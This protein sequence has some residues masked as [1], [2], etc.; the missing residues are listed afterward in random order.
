MKS[1]LGFVLVGVGVAGI[2]AACSVSVDTAGKGCPCPDGLLCDTSTNTCVTTLPVSTADG[3]SSG[4]PPVAA[5]NA[6]ECPC[7][8]NADCHDPKRAYCGPGGTC[9]E[10]LSTPSDTCTAGG[11]CNATNECVAGCKSDS[12]CSGK[13][14]NTTAHRCV[15]CVVDGDC[16][17]AGAN[18]KCSPSGTCAQSCAG[19]G[20]PC[21]TGGTCCGSF[22]L[23]TAS[24]VLNCGAC[25]NVCSTTN[26]TPTCAAGKCTFTC[27]SG[28]AH[29]G[30]PDANTGCETNIRTA[31]DCGSCGASCTKVVNA[32]GVACGTT[33]C[34]YT[35]CQQG[36][37][38][39]DKNPANGCEAD[40]GGK[41]KTCC[42]PPEQP[43]NDGSN[44][45]QN[46]SCQP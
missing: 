4:G 37:V 25:G 32:N 20:T 2:V 42:P 21:G 11:Y 22:C 36:H 9:V 12:D 18:S 30:P 34:T 43:C 45:K 23:Q 33:S 6:G 24:D 28:F 1:V 26:D 10:C 29:C 35:T 17:G 39:A 44:C 41:G 3:G 5:C 19:D 13:K 27:A 7:K 31:N 38:D 15:D 14:C 8:V 46:G 16:V 40:C